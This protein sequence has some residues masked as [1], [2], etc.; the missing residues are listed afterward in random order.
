[1]IEWTTLEQ[2][3]ATVSRRGVPA[4]R[5]HFDVAHIRERERKNKRTMPYVSNGQVLEKQSI[6]RVTIFSDVFWFIINTIGLL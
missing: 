2:K 1:M 3:M 5:Y 4:D 6:W